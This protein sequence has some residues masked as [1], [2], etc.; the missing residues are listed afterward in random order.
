MRVFANGPTNRTGSALMPVRAAMAQAYQSRG[1][2]VGLPGTMPIPAPAPAAVNQDYPFQ[3]LH[4]SNQSP[5]YWR[6]GLYYQPQAPRSASNMSIY[7]DNQMPVPAGTPAGKPAVMSRPA[8]FL[9]QNQVGAINNT[10][11]FPW[12]RG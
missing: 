8:R 12:S 3:A 9:R 10:S 2:I 6:P 7:S 1:P 4:K 5:D 11:S